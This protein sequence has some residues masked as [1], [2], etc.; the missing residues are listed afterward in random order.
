MSISMDARE[1][2]C[3][4]NEMGYKSITADQLKEF[5]RGIFVLFYLT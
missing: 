4:L 1:I 3:H 2:L 5:M